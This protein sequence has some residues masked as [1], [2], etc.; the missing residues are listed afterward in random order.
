MTD[1][2][3]SNFLVPPRIKLE[4]VVI[5]KEKLKYNIGKLFYSTSRDATLAAYSIGMRGIEV[6]L[7][8]SQEDIRKIIKNLYLKHKSADELPQKF[9]IDIQLQSTLPLLAYIIEE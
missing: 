9:K 4:V 2:D 3:F 1:F 5:P 7:S 8:S 6:D